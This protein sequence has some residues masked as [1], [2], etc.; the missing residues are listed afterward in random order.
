MSIACRVGG[1]PICHTTERNNS[2]PCSTL[3]HDEEA[4]IHGSLDIRFK[5]LDGEIHVVKC[6]LGE[7]IFNIKKTLHDQFHVPFDVVFL[8]NGS[9][10]MDP[11]SLN[12]F[13][14]LN[15]E[16]LVELQV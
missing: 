15:A 10:M 5:L 2:R 13:P 4:N 14:Q 12:D 8:L 7:T 11:L 16:S 3:G 6:K 1:T 9:P